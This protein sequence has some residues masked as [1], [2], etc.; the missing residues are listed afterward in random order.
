MGCSFRVLKF[1]S[2]FSCT[3]KPKKTKQL[4]N[5]NTYK[6]EDFSQNNPRF[7]SPRLRLLSI[8]GRN[9]A[10]QTCREFVFL[11]QGYQMYCNKNTVL[12]S[13]FIIFYFIAHM[14]KSLTA[15]TGCAVSCRPVNLLART[16][17]Y[18]AKQ[19]T[20]ID[21]RNVLNTLQRTSIVSVLL[22]VKSTSL[23][24]HVNQ[25]IVYAVT[26]LYAYCV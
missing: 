18:Y 23:N 15:L 16:V 19:L 6:C 11:S 13:C 8:T 10:L 5:L 20:E 21:A 1:V 22:V 12:Y 3:L 24:V 2:R 26:Y 4:K 14:R 9:L 25:C 17:Q 7:S